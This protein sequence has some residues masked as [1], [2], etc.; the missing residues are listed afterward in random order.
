MFAYNKIKLLKLS[1]RSRFKSLIRNTQWRWW[2]IKRILLI[3]HHPIEAATCTDFLIYFYH[4]I[5]MKQTDNSI[6]HE[7]R[8][9]FGRPRTTKYLWCQIFYASQNSE[10]GISIHFELP[11]M[12][13]SRLTFIEIAS[14]PLIIKRG[15]KIVLV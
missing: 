13:I 15:Q 9:R 12:H 6:N 4:D 1:R 7:K 2:C 10:E 8:W 3:E 5:R 14:Y 11:W